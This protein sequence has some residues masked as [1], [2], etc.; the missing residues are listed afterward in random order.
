MSISIKCKCDGI[1]MNRI[2]I[3]PNMYES[4]Q[5]SETDKRDRA[6]DK[7]DRATGT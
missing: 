1:I 4:Y 2:K 7:R 5:S 3:N 6:T